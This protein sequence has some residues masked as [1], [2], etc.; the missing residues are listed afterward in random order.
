MSKI[1]K[2]TKAQRLTL[3]TPMKPTQLPKVIPFGIEISGT[4]DI[5]K[6]HLAMTFPGVAFADTEMKGWLVAKK[7]GIKKYYQVKTIEDIR[8]FVLTAI[9]DPEV[10][11]IVIDSGSDIVDFASTEYLTETGKERIFPVVLWARVYDKIDELLLLVKQSKK[12][13]VVTSR[14][15]DE[16]VG[17]T[18][19]GKKI[20]SSYKKF[21]YQ[22]EMMLN[23]EKGITIKPKAKDAKAIVHFQD[24]VFGR[25][26]KNNFWRY[27]SSEKKPWLFDCSYDGIIAEMLEPWAGGDIVKQAESWIM[28]QERK[29]SGAGKP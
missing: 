6:T 11:T 2:Q 20:R 25:V 16:Y 8:Q 1:A 7:L 27:G 21:P 15:K 13:F 4:W 23:L 17:D 24:M 29:S 9:A 3:K 12:A 19:T 28:K 18:R 5:G 14:L 26:V 10:K 22:L